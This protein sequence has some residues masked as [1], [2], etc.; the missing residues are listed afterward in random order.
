MIVGLL[1]DLSQYSLLKILIIEAQ[2]SF[3]H[4]RCGFFYNRLYW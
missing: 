4:D 3:I 1:F 2:R